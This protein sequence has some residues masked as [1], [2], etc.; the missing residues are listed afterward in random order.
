MKKYIIIGMTAIILIGVIIIIAITSKKEPD[1]KPK[2]ATSINLFQDK[3]VSFTSEEIIIAAKNSELYKDSYNYTQTE[4]SILIKINDQEASINII[5]NYYSFK[6]LK[7]NQDYDEFLNAYGA[8]IDATQT[9]YNQEYGYYNETYKK[10]INQ[11]VVALGTYY[12]TTSEHTLIN[13]NFNHVLAVPFSNKTYT[14]SSFIP[15][16][17]N[18]YEIN[19]NQLNLNQINHAYSEGINWFSVCGK[20]INKTKG[21]RNIT[22]NIYDEN[23]NQ[24][25]QRTQQ[26]DNKQISSFCANFDTTQTE[27]NYEN[28]KYI[29]YSN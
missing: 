18:N 26:I 20:A 5:D 4:N 23:Y 29:T 7:T 28:I 25:D 19:I 13:I 9:K 12:E 8:I 6:V 3:E 27:Y 14:T 1:S 22:I 24:L 11:E 15:V 10:L 17:E 21:T 2:N 16:T